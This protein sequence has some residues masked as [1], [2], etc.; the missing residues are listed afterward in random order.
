M[1]RT[2]DILVAGIGLLCLSPLLTLVAIAIKL[3]SQGPVL[4]R[5][6]R[7]GIGFRLFW[8][9]KFRTMNVDAAKKGG[10]LT[11]QGDKRV[12]RVGALL[13]LAKLDE[14]PQLVNVLKGD[15]SL[16]GPRPEV[17]E[18]VEQFR[19]DYRKLLTV[20]PGIT[21]PASLRYRDE[22]RRLAAAEDPEHEYVARILPAKIRLAQ[23]Y[24]SQSSTAYDLLLVGR[25]IL[26]AVGARLLPQLLLRY[27]RV[28]VVVIHLFLIIASSVLAFALRFDG[29]VPQAE[30][31]LLVWTLPLLVG[32]R[33]LMFMWFR[34]Y[35]G[36][37]RYTDIIDLRNIVVA[38][39]ASSFLFYGGVHWAMDATFRRR[40]ASG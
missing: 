7:V 18:F 5:Q 10:Q 17:P 31:A 24:V 6:K 28:V 38:V 19:E 11:I 25:T 16:V 12:T 35:E 34:L 22:E 14:F 39:S 23:A 2:I 33:G 13:R 21:D 15:M 29:D 4:F 36:L 8:L 26:D 1:K 9:Y 20:R 32:V 27:R 40:C 3:D 30:L 37:W